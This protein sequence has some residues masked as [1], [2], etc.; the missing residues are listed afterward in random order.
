LF[1]AAQA[2]GLQP[3]WLTDYGIFSVSVGGRKHYVFSGVSDLNNQTAAYLARNKHATCKVLDGHELPNIPYAM[4]ETHEA[5]AAFLA[6]HIQIVVKPTLGS[7]SR[8]VHVIGREQQL[9]PLDLQHYIFEKYIE[10]RE[11]RYLVLEDKVI[12][13]Y[14]KRFEGLIVDPQTVQ[15]VAWPSGEWDQNLVKIACQATAALGLQN[16]AVDFKVT[17]EGRPYVL[18]V[19]AGA[20]IYRFQYPDEGPAVD[21][22]S[23]YIQA[24]LKKW[25]ANL[26]R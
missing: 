15:R 3:A 20:G 1:N 13:V 2:A 4:P 14:E 7:A 19:N 24:M 23:Q 17:P 9:Q 6:E 5:A 11:F 8:D 16:A 12:A 10:G 26:K 18:E 25:R 21:V 22:A